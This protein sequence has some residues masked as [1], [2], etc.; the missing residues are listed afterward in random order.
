[1]AQIIKDWTKFLIPQENYV[2]EVD[3][4]GNSFKTTDF[5]T[6]ISSEDLDKS[7][8]RNN[9]MSLWFKQQR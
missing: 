5:I 3:E 7:D 8:L 2:D 1:M 4:F 6:L 9:R